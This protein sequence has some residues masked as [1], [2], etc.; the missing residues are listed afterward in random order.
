MAKPVE[1]KGVGEVAN[2]PWMEAWSSVECCW[3]SSACTD[4][5]T[6]T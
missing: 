4:V 6:K 3:D 1:R 5:I 2:Q